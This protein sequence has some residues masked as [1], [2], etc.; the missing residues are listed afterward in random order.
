MPRAIVNAFESVYFSLNV[1][2]KMIIGVAAKGMIA[3]AVFLV[4]AMA[5]PNV[6]LYP[7]AAQVVFS[8]YYVI[9]AA[10]TIAFRC[11]LQVLYESFYREVVTVGVTKR[12]QLVALLADIEEYECVKAHFKVRLSSRIYD[13]ENE[14]LSKKWEE[15]SSHI[16]IGVLDD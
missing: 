14:D 13:D 10:R 9:Y 1:V 3:I 16:V 15:I 5:V 4:I 8:S 11:R 6:A 2:N 12:K 7:V